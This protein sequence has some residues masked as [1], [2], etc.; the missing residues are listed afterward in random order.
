MNTQ[1]LFMKKMFLWILLF[2]EK[3]FHTII[4]QN[5]FKQLFLKVDL[6]FAPLFLKVDLDFAPLF[7]K[8]D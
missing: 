2:N 1:I 4:Q 5:V 6:D 8:V 3:F 7:P